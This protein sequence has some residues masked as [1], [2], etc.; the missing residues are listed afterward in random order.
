MEKLRDFGIIPLRYGVISNLLQ[1][2][3]YPKNKVTTMEKKGELIR[4]KKGLYVVSPEISKQNLSKNLISNHLYG[5]S[6]VSLETALSYYGLIPERTITT[7]ALTAK[8]KKTYQTPLGNF[9][10]L[11]IPSQYFSIGIRQQTQNM[12][13]AF[14]I[15]SPEKALCDLII[16]RAGIRFQSMKAIKNFLLEDMRFDLQTIANWDVSIIDQCIGVGYKNNEL[17]LL[18]KYIQ[19]ENGI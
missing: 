12:E 8:R 15:A 11:S 14:L 13:Y 16:T 4:L 2:Y 18:K 19:D 9:E 3:K 6:Y 1:S 5:P 10:Y 17:K 7:Y